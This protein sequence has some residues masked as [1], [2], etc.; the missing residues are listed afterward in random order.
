MVVVSLFPF[1]SCLRTTAESTC[2][3]SPIQPLSLLRYFKPSA[4]SSVARELSSKAFDVAFWPFTDS[5]LP[6]DELESDDSESE[7]DDSDLF[8]D[9]DSDSDKK[10]GKG[11]LSA[12]G[13][14]KK[15]EEEEV[16]FEGGLS[17]EEKKEVGIRLLCLVSFS[18]L[19]FDFLD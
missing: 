5:A 1:L 8:S 18:S 16:K 11:K 3:D 7:I 9:D 19:R 2:S 6:K 4:T 14:G 10:K 15:A 17:L 13:K 12:K